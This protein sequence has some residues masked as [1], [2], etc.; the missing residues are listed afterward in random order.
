[1]PIIFVNGL[2]KNMARDAF[3]NLWGR[4][5]AAVIGVKELNLSAGEVTIWFVPDMWDYGLGKEIVTLLV[6]GL[7]EKPERTLEVRNRLAEGLKDVIYKFFPAVKKC[8]CPIYPFNP[9]WGFA[10]FDRETEQTEQKATVA[11]EA[12]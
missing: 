1:M 3:R 6:F 2:P 7:Y 11:G 10:V 9:D 12:W 8:E 5:T 4:M